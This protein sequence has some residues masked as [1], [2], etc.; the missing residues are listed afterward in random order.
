MF[1]RRKGYDELPIRQCISLIVD[2]I[3]ARQLVSSSAKPNGV[4][5]CEICR[6][7]VLQIFIDLDHE[8]FLKARQEEL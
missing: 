3:L 5:N 7:V 1:V 2:V 6:C 8:V 4:E